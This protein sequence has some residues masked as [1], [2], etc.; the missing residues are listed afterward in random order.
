M[1]LCLEQVGNPAESAKSLLRHFATSALLHTALQETAR[2]SNQWSWLWG[3]CSC[4]GSLNRSC[5]CYISIKTSF[6]TPPSGLA[7]TIFFSVLCKTSKPGVSL[8][9][10]SKHANVNRTVH[11]TTLAGYNYTHIFLSPCKY[12]K[13]LYKMQANC[14]LRSPGQLDWSN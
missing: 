14:W 9:L 8:S 1:E 10:E 11:S 4:W 6:T 12:W 3:R 2:Q 7:L 13:N 5:S